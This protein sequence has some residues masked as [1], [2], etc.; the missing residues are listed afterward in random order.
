[1]LDF[2]DLLDGVDV[3]KKHPSDEDVGGDANDQTER[4]GEVFFSAGFFYYIVLCNSINRRPSRFFLNFS[5]KDL[6]QL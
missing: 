5:L 4:D 2:R 1:M 3:T 6:F